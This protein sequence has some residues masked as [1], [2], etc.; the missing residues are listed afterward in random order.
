MRV[1]LEMEPGDLVQSVEVLE[2]IHGRLTDIQRRKWSRLTPKGKLRLTQ[3]LQTV[4][5]IHSKMK[6][7]RNRAHAQG[8]L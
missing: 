1:V 7:A 2:D 6:D 8:R 5:T 4:E 3:Q